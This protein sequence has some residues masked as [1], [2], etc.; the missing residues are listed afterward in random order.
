V[1]EI[2]IPIPKSSL[3]NILKPISRITD[4]CTITA[5]DNEL[6]SLCWSY[7]NSLILFAK[8]NI[9]IALPETK[10]NIISIKKLLTGLDCLGDDGDFKLIYNN[11][12]IICKSVNEATVENTHFKYHLVDDTSIK[13]GSIP[14]ER[15]K[16][17]KADTTFNLSITKIKQIMSAYTFTDD[18]N[19]IFFYSKEGKVFAEIDDTNLPNKD[20]VCLVVSPTFDGEEISI[21]IAIKIEVFK[22]LISNRS[23][24]K[25]KVN[26]ENRLFVFNTQE[27]DNTE[28]KYIISTLV[29]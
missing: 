8:A 23:D 7:D 17:L 28:L 20:S 26:N 2:L 18:I 3:E 12:H 21:P 24:V 19:K 5:K 15:I 13:A 4:S 25:V 14:I 10:L 16:G 9:P 11:N 27:D 22:N 6:Y 29:K 1:S